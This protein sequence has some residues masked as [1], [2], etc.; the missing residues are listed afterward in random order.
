MIPEAVLVELRR[1]LVTRQ[2]DDVNVLGE[3][4][5]AALNEKD[6]FKPGEAG[7][8]LLLT[9]RPDPDA[10][11]TWMGAA[12]GSEEANRGTHRPI[13]GTGLQDAMTKALA[14][15]RLSYESLACLAHD[16][17]GPERRAVVLGPWDGKDG[18]NHG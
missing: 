8:A 6:G 13:T 1:D 12:A 14:Q 7:V 17:S 16:F 4:L 15:A 9:N 18:S 5:V 3:A 11:A 2:L 10:M